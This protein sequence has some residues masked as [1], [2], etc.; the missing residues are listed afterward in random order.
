MNISYIYP[1]ENNVVIKYNVNDFLNGYLLDYVYE[2][3]SEV[4]EGYALY[5]NKILLFKEDNNKL[6][7]KEYKVVDI[8]YKELPNKNIVLTKDYN[9]DGK[10]D[11]KILYPKTEEDG[12]YSPGNYRYYLSNNNNFNYNESLSSLINEISSYRSSGISIDQTKQRLITS[13]GDGCCFS[14]INEYEFIEDVL[15]EVAQYTENGLENPIYTEVKGYDNKKLKID[16]KYLK[17]ENI[18]EY[19]SFNTGNGKGVVKLF[20]YQNELFYAF[21]QEGEKI[22]FAYPT[23]PNINKAKFIYTI[24]NNELSFSSGPVTY[25][26]YEYGIRINIKGKVSNWVAGDTRSGNLRQLRELNLVNLEKKK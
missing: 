19:L 15:S 11:I 2:E 9:F 10:P 13:I 12:S 22:Y 6:F 1:K 23:G 5:K 25:T 14:T 7:D 16:Y 8:S 21:V 17:T 24:E 3:G 20:D 4:L 18:R 26:I